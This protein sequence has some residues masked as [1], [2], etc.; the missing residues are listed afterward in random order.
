[1]SSVAALDLE[2][3]AR[4]RARG[5]PPRRRQQ[6]GHAVHQR[7]DAR[8]GQRRAEEHRAGQ[9]APGLCREFPAQPAIGDRG[10]AADVR[11]HDRLVLLGQHFGQPGHEG[12]VGAV[13]P[14]DAGRA[15][16]EL[17]YRAHR[18]DRRRQPLGDVSQ[19]AL[20][21][22]ATPVDL[23]H[24]QHGRDAQPLQRAHQDAGLR[25]DPF[26][27][28]D[29]QHRPVEHAQRPLHLGDEVRVA[30]RVD[31]VDDDVAYRERGHGGLD[32]DAALPFQRQRVGLGGAVIDTADLVD[33]PGR[34]EQPFGQGGLTGVYMRQD[35]QVQ[36]SA[37]HASYPPDRWK[38]P[39]RWI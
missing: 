16:A 21:A 13:R 2:H 11:G 8:P 30:R 38:S 28:R 37:S 19:Q 35:P 39:C 23:V 1:V 34:V 5:V 25:L 22:R 14:G 32:R 15:R 17:A 20:I 12:G 9:P 31:E 29:H 26:D 27:G 10:L 3:L 18:D 4:G 24:E 6:L 33:D 36:R 7:A